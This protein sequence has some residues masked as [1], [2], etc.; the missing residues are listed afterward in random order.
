M[1]IW[2]TL[3]G[4]S[5]INP[6][7]YPVP[8]VGYEADDPHISYLETEDGVNLAMRVLRAPGNRHTLLFS[9]GNAEDIGQNELD[10]QTL[11]SYGVDVLA[12]D[13]RGYGHSGGKPSEPGTY[14]DIE[15]VYE[16]ARR[17]R[18]EHGIV[19]MGRSLGGGPSTELA[20]RKP[21]AGLVLASTYTSI[22]DVVKLGWLGKIYHNL[23]KIDAVDCPVFIVHGDRDE[24]IPFAHGEQLFAR[25]REPKT[26]L[27]VR[28]GPHDLLFEDAD[29]GER[30]RKWLA[31][32]P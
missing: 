20:R 9:H 12:Y 1:G 3:S 21:V 29:Y 16:F 2:A 5:V 23:G 22:F 30:L 25:A 31:A 4:W 32:L 19:L 6:A 18:P 11:H 13:Y 17:E 27:R 14:R 10:L 26:F 7:L 24:V 15:A 8:P 28:G